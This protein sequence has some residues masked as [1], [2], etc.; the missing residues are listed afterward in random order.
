[1]IRFGVEAQGEKM[2]FEL[3]YRLTSANEP[4]ELPSPT[5]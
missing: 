2:Q 3:R 1:L 5:G 4:V